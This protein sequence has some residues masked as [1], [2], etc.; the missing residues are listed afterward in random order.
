MLPTVNKEVEF[1]TANECDKCGKFI[2][3]AKRDSKCRCCDG[4]IEADRIHFCF[5]YQ[6]GNWQKTLRICGFCLWK[7]LTE[8]KI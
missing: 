1:M 2:D 3:V 5:R 8:V 6:D 4:L 7:I